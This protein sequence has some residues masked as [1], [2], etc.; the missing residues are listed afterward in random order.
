MRPGEIHMEPTLIVPLIGSVESVHALKTAR[1]AAQTSGGRI[2]LLRAVAGRDPPA[3]REGEEHARREL[4]LL[5]HELRKDG[6]AAEAQVR[7]ARPG[8]AIIGAVRE[9]HASVI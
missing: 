4:E 8:V 5:A 3:S 2:G 9:Y 1:A 6:I 7:R